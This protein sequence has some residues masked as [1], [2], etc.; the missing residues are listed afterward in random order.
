[1]KY[2]IGARLTCYED[3]AYDVKVVGLGDDGKGTHV[4]QVR[5]YDYPHAVFWTD[6]AHLGDLQGR[7]HDENLLTKLIRKKA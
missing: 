1:M 5:M 3:G 6:E 2:K 4:Y 7:R